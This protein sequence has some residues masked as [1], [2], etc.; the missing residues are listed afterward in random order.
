[1]IVLLLPFA[2]LVVIVLNATHS[3][4]SASDTNFVARLNIDFAAVVARKNSDSIVRMNSDSTD[5]LNIDIIAA[6]MTTHIVVIDGIDSDTDIIVTSVE[7]V[8]LVFIV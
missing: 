8:L 2:L 7:Y 5:Y 4:D 6:T 3:T 1:M